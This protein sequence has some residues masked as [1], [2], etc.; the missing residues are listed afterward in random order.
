M[1][2]QHRNSIHNWI[3][4]SAAGAYHGR[5]FEIQARVAHRANDIVRPLLQLVQIRISE[6]V[7]HRNALVNRR[8]GSALFSISRFALRPAHELL[9]DALVRSRMSKFVGH[10]NAVVNGAIV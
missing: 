3:R 8:V 1:R 6:L 5:L 9:L 2:D 10:A 7:F 4:A